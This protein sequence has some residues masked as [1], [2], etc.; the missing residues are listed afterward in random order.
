MYNFGSGLRGI[1][2]IVRFRYAALSAGTTVDILW[3]CRDRRWTGN[4]RE[5]ERHLSLPPACSPLE[6]LFPTLCHKKAG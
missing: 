3:S 4:K 2:H 6:T 5:L 1:L